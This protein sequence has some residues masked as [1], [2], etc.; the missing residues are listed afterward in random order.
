MHNMRAWSVL[1]IML[2]GLFGF[3]GCRSEA[4]VP[5]EGKV[6]LNNKPLAEATVLFSPT[7][8][9]GAGPFAGT[10]DREGR[11]VLGPVGNEKA[12]AAP[13]T[14]IVMITTAKPDPNAPDGPPLQKELVPAAF[15][16]GSKRYEI[17]ASGDKEVIFDI[18]ASPAI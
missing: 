3:A 5:V 14:Y 9:N 4:L 17:S 16:D 8:A 12:G 7:R 6:Q 15:N 18:K 1:S 10:T 11:F 13:G 2:C